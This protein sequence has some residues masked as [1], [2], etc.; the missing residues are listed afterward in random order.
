MKFDVL[1]WSILIAFLLGNLVLGYLVGGKVTTAREFNI[2]NGRTPWWAI[3]L[4]VIATYISAL[5]FLGA[6]A[7][8]YKDGLAA[9][10][11]HLNYPIVILLVTSF[12]LPFFYAS[13]VA[14]IYDY[15]E[16]RFGP[17]SRAV[18]STIFLVTQGLST[19]AILYA[20]A[21]VLQFI[22][23]ISVPA[24]IVLITVMA[25]IYT[26]MGGMLAVIWTDVFQAAVL[27][28][29]AIV[30]M[31]ALIVAM[32][33]PILEVLANLKSLG[34]LNAMNPAP[35]ITISTTIWSGLIGMTLFHI[36]V[37]GANQMMVQRTLG[38]A[39]IGDA[40]KAYLLMGYAAFPIYFLF[41]F[42]GVLAYGYYGGK[43]FANNNE[44]ILQFAADSGVPGLLGILA[45]AV[46]AASMS[47]LSSAFNS[48]AT[49]SVVDF[50]Q[51]YFKRDESDAHYLLA[52]R[53]A[54]VFWAVLIIFP[55]I[56]YTRS[57]GS[58]L[59]VISKIGS[60]FVGAKLGMY[61]L[62]FFSK[63]TTERGL[64][65]GVVAGFAIIWYVATQTRIAWPWFCLI[66]GA[67][68][69]IVGWSMSRVLDGKQAEWSA[70]SIPGQRARFA[71][72]GR[73]TT[74]GKWNTVPG[75]IDKQAWWLVVYLVGTLLL[76]VLLEALV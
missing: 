33:V 34:R 57:D 15:Q 43:P 16:R 12:F 72:E 69:T 13:G 7:W 39:T 8:A 44:I 22:T 49:A 53:W 28:G 62:G 59:E 46:L 76:L 54:T 65:F 5:S 56:L 48:M 38:A 10:A 11:I 71:N 55:A 31:V 42:I 60:Y 63:H 70:Y 27:F 19:G 74:Q 24:G 29:G 30:I 40:K 45:A 21:L 23:G 1:D 67:I 61:A 6:P 64:M 35:D 26:T 2:G 18:M 51:R 3:G 68:T 14:S 50:Y 58:I 17:T 36:T 47:T 37:Y 41:F 75:E 25:L 4:S 32:P 20:T 73:A 66:G 9:L 52:T